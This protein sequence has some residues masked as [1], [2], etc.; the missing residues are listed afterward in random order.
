MSLPIQGLGA[1]VAITMVFA[2]FPVPTFAEEESLQIEEIVV[3]ARRRSESL[4]E[5]PLSIVAFDESDIANL[6]VIAIKDLSKFSPGLN[7]EGGVDNN[8]SRFFLRGVGTATP[9]FGT[10]SGV[11]I[12]IDDIYTPLGLGS[13]IEIFSIDRVEVLSGPQGTLYGR[14]SFGGAIKVYSKQFTDEISG[15]VSYTV[16]SY[17]Q[18]NVKGEF[19]APIIEDK[20]FFGLAAAS[21]QNDGIQDLINIPGGKGWQDDKELYRIRLEARPTERLTAKFSYEEN[22]DQGLTKQIKVLPGSNGDINGA[23]NPAI[24]A[25][26]QAII[27]NGLMI[28]PLPM[29]DSVQ[30]LGP[31]DEDDIESDVLSNAVVE[32]ESYTWNIAFDINENM[33]LRY[34]GST[35]EQNNIRA[36]DIDGTVAPFLPVR[37]QFQF[38]ADS[39]EL[40]FEY[41]GDRLAIAAGVFLYEE[42]TDVHQVFNNPFLLGFVTDSF[43]TGTTTDGTRPFNPTVPLQAIR[44]LQG[45]LTGLNVGIAMN[46]HRQETESEAI[47]V[48]ASYEFTEKLTASFG[49]R[50]TQD[51]KTAE[52]PIGNFDTGLSVI[53]NPAQFPA[54][55]DIIPPGGVDTRQFVD[56]VNG[57]NNA[58]FQFA[59]GTPLTAPGVDLFGDVGTISDDF[60]ELTFEF[61][62]DYQLDES[63]LLYGSFKQ[64]FQAGLLSPNNTAVQA[65][66][67][68]DAVPQSTD[69]QTIDSVEV[70]FKS[71]LLDGR[72]QLNAAAYWY[73]WSDVILF[74]QVEVDDPTLASSGQLGVV[75]NSG[76]ATTL[77]LEIDAKYLISESF[78]IYGNVAWH[79]FELDSAQGFDQAS[80]SITDI[81][82]NFNDNVSVATPDFKALLGAEVFLNYDFGELRFWANAAYRDDIG[83]NNRAQSQSGGLNILTTLDDEEAYTSESFTN[84][85]AGVT[86]ET[87]DEKWRF[88]L[89]GSNLTDKRRI[90][91]TIYDVPGFFGRGQLY[92]QPRIWR[93]TAKYSF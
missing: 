63:M 68:A 6:N 62:L 55:G 72:L 88:D 16:G 69:A 4:Q 10:E 22:N 3:S 15:D 64:G 11:P 42:D 93:L 32:Q 27:D 33:T 85:S 14:N 34:L 50:Y 66:F 51:E 74:T 58:G 29:L 9:T 57:P 79:D 90:E 38:D 8:T 40:R 43:V 46:Q 30:V 5:V 75:T 23:I 13:N 84:I 83:T 7:I 59:A 18:R 81:T 80:G 25:H 53:L 92:N 70:G 20:L 44:D 89:T 45:N 56:L 67:P 1:F 41:V 19:Q 48:N 91:S 47:Y 26:N 60:D 12:Y 86:V 77:G 52:T 36:F 2:A 28:D 39:H 24:E 76:E 37:E 61:T 73:D 87:S 49:V 35:R 71:I 31:S 21:I 78:L 82:N 54:T 65:G 17:G